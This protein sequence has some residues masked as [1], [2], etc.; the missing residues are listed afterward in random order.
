MVNPPLLQYYTPM[1]QISNQ[2]PIRQN[3]PTFCFGGQQNIFFNHNTFPA[4]LAMSNNLGS[5]TFCGVLPL[6]LPTQPFQ[7]TQ[8]LGPPNIGQLTTPSDI[9][10]DNNQS[11]NITCDSIN[12][13]V[14][15]SNSLH[16]SEKSNDEIN[17]NSCTQE[18][19]PSDILNSVN[20]NNIPPFY[21]RQQFSSLDLFQRHFYSYTHSMGV[22]V[23]RETTRRNK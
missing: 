1:M 13:D 9:C 23:S 21:R 18:F 16:I 19:I 15:E 20:D 7:L 14:N 2:N 10:Q 5:Y 4:N 17:V 12:D 6:P 3:N 8:I 11:K 22:S